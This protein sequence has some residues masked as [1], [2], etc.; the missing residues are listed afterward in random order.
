VSCHDLE[1]FLSVIIGCGGFSFD[2]RGE[3]ISGVG[4]VKELAHAIVLI[5]VRILTLNRAP[6]M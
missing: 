4:I 2:G 1:E 3:G 5:K 6:G